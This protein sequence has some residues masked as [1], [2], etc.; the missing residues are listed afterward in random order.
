VLKNTGSIA[1]KSPSA[2]T[3]TISTEPTIPHQ[4]PMP[5][6]TLTHPPR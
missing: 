1:P 3:R 4:P 6:F 5:V 2:R